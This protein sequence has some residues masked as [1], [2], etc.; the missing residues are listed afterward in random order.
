MKSYVFEISKNRKPKKLGSKPREDFTLELTEHQL[1]GIYFMLDH[2]QVVSNEEPRARIWEISDNKGKRYL[3][4]VNE[5]YFP[6]SEYIWLTN[7]RDSGQ[8]SE[9]L[10][11]QLKKD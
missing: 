6:M 11:Q 5:H 8:S 7:I 4:S 1:R 2:L 10:L 9:E 3:R